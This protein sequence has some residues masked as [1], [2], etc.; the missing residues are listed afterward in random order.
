MGGI[1]N[2]HT[3]L[4]VTVA[5][6][7]ARAVTYTALVERPRAATD[8]A[9]IEHVAVAVASALREAGATTDSAL[10]QHMAVAVALQGGTEYTSFQVSCGVTEANL[11]LSLGYQRPR[12]NVL[13]AIFVLFATHY[14]KI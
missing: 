11:T 13:W 1:V 5:Q 6:R 14:L 10:V 12:K 2:I 3:H 4:A 7:D 9:L 8:A